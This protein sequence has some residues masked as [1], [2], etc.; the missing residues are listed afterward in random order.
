[1]LVGGSAYKVALQASEPRIPRR[2]KVQP[3]ERVAV[4]TS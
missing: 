3:K 4:S 1:M 2:P